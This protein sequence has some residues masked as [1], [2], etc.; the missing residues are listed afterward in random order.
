V[1]G[2]AALELLQGLNREHLQTIILATHSQEAARRAGRIVRLRDGKI[3][4]SESA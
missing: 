2:G 1:A 4:R 3:E